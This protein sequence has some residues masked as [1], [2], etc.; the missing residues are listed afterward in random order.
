MDSKGNAKQI[1]KGVDGYCEPGHMLAIMGP[2][3]SGKSTML[4]TLS[5]RMTGNVR[6]DGE[7]AV[8]GR[9]AS[10][11][12]GKAAF[13]SQVTGRPVAV[14]D[15]PTPLPAAARGSPS[16]AARQTPRTVCDEVHDASAA[17]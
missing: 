1:L 16:C 3:G 13:V 7:M 12:Y 11:V 9:A 10:L 15:P 5:G 4:D 14:H 8:N 17:L 6:I 2:S